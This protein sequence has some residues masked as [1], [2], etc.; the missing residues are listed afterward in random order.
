M[1][2]PATDKRQRLVRAAISQF[3]ERGFA[4]TALSAV[5]KAAGIAPGNVFY[6][7]R[8]KEELA[9]AVV[10]AWCEM[11]AGFLGELAPDGDPWARIA[12]FID[13]AQRMAGVYLAHGCPLAG[14]A[15]DLRQESHALGAEAARI[16]AIQT[17]WLTDQFTA[18]GLPAA[19]AASHARALMAGQH[20]AIL[21]AHAQGDP[22]L[23]ASQ[24]A[25]LHA[26]LAS[27][28]AGSGRAG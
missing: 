5:A 28:R 2:R 26:W 20:G 22:E 16:Y 14:L 15:R 27:L 10:D 3:H 21:L 23:I 6:H 12:A 7:F 4:Q 17:G 18:A 13:Q 8:T 24:V 19:A 1:G 25:W 11:Q 9:R